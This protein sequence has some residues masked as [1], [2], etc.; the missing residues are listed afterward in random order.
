MMLVVVSGVVGYSHRIVPLVGLSLMVGEIG[1][2][3][4]EQMVLLNEERV[5]G[6]RG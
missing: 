5:V 3:Q 4:L 1:G 6:E 2:S